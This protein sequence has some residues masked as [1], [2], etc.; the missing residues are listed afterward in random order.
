MQM[1][2]CKEVKIDCVSIQ[3]VMSLGIFPRIATG[4]DGTEDIGHNEDS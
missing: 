4:F 3:T 2:F 1:I